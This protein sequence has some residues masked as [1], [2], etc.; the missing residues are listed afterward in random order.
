MRFAKTDIEGLLIIDP[1]LHADERGFF[2]R[3]SCPDEFAREGIDFRPVQTSV[4]RNDAL[5]TLRGMHYCREP[6]AKLVRC[7]RGAILDVVF[8]IRRD[9][10]SFG[11]AVG[12]DLDDRGLRALYIPAGLAHGFLT[13]K[14]D[15]DVL[16]QI[17]RIFRP[18]FDEGLRWNDPRF[19]FAW[20][21]AP[22]VIGARDANWPDFV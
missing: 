18:G 21:A 4:S 17:D 22:A 9:S 7:A 1:D 16:Y 13:L 14:P 20:P 15:S 6:E 10:P 2:A 8:D 5:H 19:S 12:V 3:L 11:R